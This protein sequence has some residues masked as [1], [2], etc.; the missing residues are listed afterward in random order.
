MWSN[1]GTNRN[2]NQIL[3]FYEWTPSQW[4]KHDFISHKQP[5]SRLWVRQTLINFTTWAKCSIFKSA[6]DQTWGQILY[7]Q[8]QAT[9]H[10]R[11]IFLALIGCSKLWVSTIY[12]ITK[13]WCWSSYL[14]HM[15]DMSY[16]MCWVTVVPYGLSGPTET[17][18]H[19]QASSRQ[20]LLNVCTALWKTGFF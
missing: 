15:F 6:S 20:Q 5:G 9:K 3:C 16:T 12:Q 1:H 2:T 17:P 8:D 18:T 7:W 13:T 4:N 19:S 14:S 10:P 11:E